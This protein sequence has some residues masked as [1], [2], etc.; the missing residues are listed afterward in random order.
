MNNVI[1]IG[2]TTHND[3]EVVVVQV[4][5]VTLAHSHVMIEY[6]DSE[7]DFVEYWT[8]YFA[9]AIVNV[10]AEKVHQKRPQ[11]WTVQTRLSPPPPVLPREGEEG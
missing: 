1:R 10:I 4:L 2:K 8:G 3:E 5:G 11:G 9:E 7:P 6:F